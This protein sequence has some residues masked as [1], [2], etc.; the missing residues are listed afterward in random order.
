MKIIKHDDV[1]LKVI[2]EA[3]ETQA[4]KSEI[5]IKGTKLKLI[6]SGVYLEACIQYDERYLVFTTDGCPFEESL[7]IYLLS[8]DN[9]IIDSATAFCPYGTGSFQLLGTT[10]SDSVQF[11][12][13]IDKYWKI[14]ILKSNRINIP[15]IS[16]P[17]GV[18]RKIKFCRSFGVSEVSA[19]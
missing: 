13:F 19:Q 9:E 8:G 2:S 11:K 12:F 18:W 16:E 6:I 15:Y 4:P 14:K 10:D 1:N 5:T 17:S 3:T 7:N